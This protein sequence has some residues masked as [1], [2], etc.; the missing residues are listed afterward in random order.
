MSTLSH[1]DTIDTEMQVNLG[2]LFSK[3]RFFFGIWAQMTLLMSLQFLAPN[4]AVHI[5]SYGY[6][7]EVVGVCYGIPGILFAIGA[8]FVHKLTARLERRGVM[9]IG[10]I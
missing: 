9:L 5:A 1:R 7:P 4:L 8:P 3:P 6:S 10:W 2:D